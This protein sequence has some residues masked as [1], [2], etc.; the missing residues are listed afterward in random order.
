MSSA[1]NAVCMAISAPGLAG[2]P[3]LTHYD[4]TSL[5]PALAPIMILTPID[6]PFS[7]QQPPRLVLGLALVLL[8]IFGFWHGAD[9]QR[10]AALASQYRQQ[11]LATEWPLYETHLLKTSQRQSLALLKAAHSQGRD[12]VLA[13]YIGADEAFVKSVQAQGRDYL[14]EEELQRWQSARAQFDAEHQKLSAEALGLDPEHF[15]PITFLTFSLVQPDALSLLCALLL[16][17]SAGMAL[18]LALGSGAVLSAFFG[19]GVAGACV[20]LLSNGNNTLPLA[21]AMAASAGLI[22][23]Y[24]L[25]FRQQRLRFCGRLNLPALLLL[26]LWLVLLAAWYWLY[27]PRLPDMLAVL[28]GLLSAPLWWW[29]QQRFF[30]AHRDL[31]P[32]LPEAVPDEQDQDYRAQLQAALDAVARMDFA[33]AQKRLRELVKAR[34]QDMRVL[35]QLFHLEKL[36]PDS[37]TFD[38]ISRRLFQ[39]G[40]HDEDSARTALALYREYDKLSAEKR[41]LDSETSL[42]LIIRF[43]RIGEVKDAEKLMK[44]LLARKTSHALLGKA[45]HALAQACEQ[46]HDPARAE[47]YRQ[48]A[49]Q[50]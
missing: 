16:L 22:G 23:F 9:R 21:G 33:E 26:P 8:I 1:P 43:A 32:T 37:T 14:S 44:A 4:E 27:T 2:K 12:D 34:P 31:L 13:R 15:R 28:G 29:L 38:A 47:Q 42:K 17:L 40:A 45:A 39:L 20:Y 46:L 10:E 30:P 3:A 25:H 11:L 50:N 5:F 36:Q 41:A 18:E 49:Q 48:L 24:S 6:P 7:W 19:G 35:C